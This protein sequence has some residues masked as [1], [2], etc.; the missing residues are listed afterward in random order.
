[1]SPT[2]AIARR[3]GDGPAVA[4]QRE[5]VEQRLRG[6]LVAAVT[7]VDDAGVDPSARPDAARRRTVAHHHRVDAHRLDRLHGVEQALALLHRRARTENVIV[8]A[9]RRFAAVSNER[10]VRVESS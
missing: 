10:R 4:S 6:V 9:D 1:M 5:R 2:I 8:S 3:R 7:G